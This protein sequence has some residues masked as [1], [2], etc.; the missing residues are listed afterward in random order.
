MGSPLLLSNCISLPALTLFPSDDMAAAD[1]FEFSGNPK[2]TLCF[3][4]SWQ[5]CKSGHG[6]LQTHSVYAGRNGPEGSSYFN[7]G[8]VVKRAES[9]L[10]TQTSSRGIT[11]SFSLPVMP[12]HPT[13]HCSSLTCSEDAHN[14]LKQHEWAENQ[15]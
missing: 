15:A 12:G 6:A 8:G 11:Q 10:E 4:L 13:H 9:C 1:S 14:Q 2:R 5:H 3:P 7:L